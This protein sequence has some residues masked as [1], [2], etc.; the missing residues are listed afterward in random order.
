MGSGI[1][2]VF[3]S[4]SMIRGTEYFP[5]KKRRMLVF[6][7]CLVMHTCVSGISVRSERTNIPTQEQFKNQITRDCHCITLGTGY[8]IAD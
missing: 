4:F 6:F 2:Y 3:F 8:I 5:E 7:G 1:F